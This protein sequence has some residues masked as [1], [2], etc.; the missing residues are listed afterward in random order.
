MIIRGECF[1][2]FLQVNL[3]KLKIVDDDKQEEKS[4][5]SSKN[6][7]V[8]SDNASKKRDRPLRKKDS[9]TSFSHAWLAG[10][11]K[12]HGSDILGLDFSQNGKYVITC[13]GG[14]L[15]EKSLFLVC[16][17]LSVFDFRKMAIDRQ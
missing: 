13:A 2:W 8:K 9:K 10:T 11:L 5:P 4:K 14:D 17:H 12:G 1:S 15:L 6:G 3:T 16:T 7:Q